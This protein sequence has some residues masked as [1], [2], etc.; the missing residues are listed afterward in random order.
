MPLILSSL[1]FPT[2]NHRPSPS[3][4]IIFPTVN[5]RPSPSFLVIFPTVN[6]RPSPSFLVIFPTGRFNPPKTCTRSRKSGGSLL[7]FRSSRRTAAR[8]TRTKGV[9][10]SLIGALT[11]VCLK[12]IFVYVWSVTMVQCFVG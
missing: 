10:E 5:Y 3:F 8:P 2:V 6:H 11:Y 1:S 7:S 4:L 12:L 9:F